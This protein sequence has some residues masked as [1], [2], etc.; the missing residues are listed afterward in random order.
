MQISRSP[1]MA[2]APDHP[3]QRTGHG[4]YVEAPDGRVFHTFLCGRPI[5]GGF[6]PLGRETGLAECEWHDDGW[7]YLKGGGML[8]PLDLPR[9]PTIR[10][11]P[12]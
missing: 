12:S 8:P 10:R 6:C 7:L 4:Q 2:A 1:P 11:A 5:A 3:L 9:R